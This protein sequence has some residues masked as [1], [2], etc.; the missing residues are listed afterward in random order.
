LRNREDRQ[1]KP[2][3]EVVAFVYQKAAEFV[4]PEGAV[5]A[6][7]LC[8]DEDGGLACN[9]GTAFSLLGGLGVVIVEGFEVFL[10]LKG[11]IEL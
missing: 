8:G 3:D 5:D 9:G 6:F 4:E 10:K 7:W 1:K 2:N 11:G